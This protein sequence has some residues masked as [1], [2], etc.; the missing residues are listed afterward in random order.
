MES[1]EKV[2][3]SCQ[4]KTEERNKTGKFEHFHWTFE[5]LNLDKV[6]SVGYMDGNCSAFLKVGLN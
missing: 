6:P 3:N 4:S 5:F 1:F 2:V